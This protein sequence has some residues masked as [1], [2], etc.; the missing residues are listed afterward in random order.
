MDFLA[1]LL[2]GVVAYLITVG[3]LAVTLDYFS[4]T[5]QQTLYVI[6]FDYLFQTIAAYALVVHSVRRLLL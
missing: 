6:F 1:S 4:I 5:T 2:L 3:F